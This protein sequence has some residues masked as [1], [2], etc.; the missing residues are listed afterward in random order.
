[1][2]LLVLKINCPFQ[3]CPSTSPQLNLKSCFWCQRVDRGN[4]QPF[5]IALHWE[6]VQVLV[7]CSKQ[8]VV[9]VPIKD[10]SWDLIVKKKKK[11][12]EPASK[13]TSRDAFNLAPSVVSLCPFFLWY[14]VVVFCW[15]TEAQFSMFAAVCLEY[16]L[17]CSRLRIYLI[18]YCTRCYSSSHN[19]SHVPF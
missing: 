14:N 7:S 12:L 11:Y 6:L 19:K 13:V 3:H 10:K 1:M 5:C 2:N 17:A 15:I 16:T 9:G 4:S 8:Q 18:Q